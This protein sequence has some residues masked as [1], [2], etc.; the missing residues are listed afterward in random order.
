MRKCATTL[1]VALV[2]LLAAGCSSHRSRPTAAATTT[3]TTA[4]TMVTPAPT[5]TAGPTADSLAERLYAV[6]TAEDTLY[7]NSGKFTADLATLTSVDPSVT[8]GSGLAPPTNPAAVD[9]AVSGDGQWACFTALSTAGQLVV[10]AIGAP[11]A[12]QYEGST[13]LTVCSAATVHAMTAMGG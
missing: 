6:A 1:G 10:E 3:I 5:T 11:P 13:Q 12:N 4:T 8:Y 7:T 2:M 9:V